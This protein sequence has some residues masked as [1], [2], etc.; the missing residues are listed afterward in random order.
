MSA[1]DP[2]ARAMGFIDG[3]LDAAEAAEIQKLIAADPEFAQ[4]I[5]EEKAFKAGLT[6]KLS[7]VPPPTQDLRRNFQRNLNAEF[8]PPPARPIVRPSQFYWRSGFAAAAVLLI[9]AFGLFELKQ[10]FSNECLY[11]LACTE[12]H[13]HLMNDPAALTAKTTDSRIATQSVS[14][15]IKYQ[16]P[17]VPDFSGHA[18]NLDGLAKAPFKSLKQYDAP[19]GV[20]VH[21]SGSDGGVS[22][23]YHLWPDETPELFNQR[24]VKGQIYWLASHHGIQVAAWKSPDGQLLT[25]VISKWPLERVLKL[26]EEARADMEGRT[27]ESAP[28]SGNEVE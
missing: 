16:I 4:F 19:D 8:T 3:E 5:E 11:M 25:S 27:A 28:A 2:H 17:P 22:V 18:L 9:A 7:E 20:L 14:K 10:I 21:Y 1:S 24:L 15:S 26:A 13:A 23:V 6:H 12:E